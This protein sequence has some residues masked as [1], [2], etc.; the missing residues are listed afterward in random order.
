MLRVK[1]SDWTS[2]LQDLGI[3]AP[4]RDALQVLRDAGL[5]Q[6]V[7]A[8]PKHP[9]HPDAKSFGLYTERRERDRE[10]RAPHVAA[11]G[12]HRLAQLTQC[13]L[14]AAR[15]GGPLCSVAAPP[16]HHTIA[17]ARGAP[18]AACVRRWG[19][20]RGRCYPGATPDPAVPHGEG[21][22][23]CKCASRRPDSNR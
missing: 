6:K 13:E 9:G 11:C 19:G 2:W 7:Y 16:A 10:A 22:M 15:P 17:R 8:L 4:K 12:W 1:P 21:Q 3:A 14:Q 23:P 18:Q 20:K 5:V